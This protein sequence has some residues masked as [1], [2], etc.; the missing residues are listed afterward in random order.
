MLKWRVPESAFLT[1]V[2]KEIIPLSASVTVLKEDIHE[3]LTG[4]I[5][6]VCQIPVVD[7]YQI[8]PG[9]ETCFPRGCETL[10]V[11]SQTHTINSWSFVFPGNPVMSK[12]NGSYP[13]RCTPASFPST[14]TFVSQSHASKFKR[15]CFLF[16]VFGMVKVLLYQRFSFSVTFF[17]TPD[18]ADSTG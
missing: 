18:R 1:S 15:R 10:S 6:T 16:H 17:F 11:G 3:S 5:H 2:L 8:L 4:S 13:P 12:V 14:H 9:A 7:V